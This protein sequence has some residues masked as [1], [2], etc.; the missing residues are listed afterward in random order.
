VSF[1][2]GLQLLLVN[3]AQNGGFQSGQHSI[4]RRGFCSLGIVRLHPNPPNYTKS[5]EQH[6][7][8][9]EVTPRICRWLLTLRAPIDHGLQFSDTFVE[10]ETDSNKGGNRQQEN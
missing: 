8:F 9:L 1:E 7:D 4:K 2:I 5:E 6:N 10:P 3:G